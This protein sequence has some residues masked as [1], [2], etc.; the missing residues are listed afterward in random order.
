LKK[1]NKIF[2]IAID[3]SSASG[4]T[5]GAKFISKKFNFKFLS[6]GKLYR[7]LS[8]K[9]IQNKYNYDQKFILYNSK[10]IT[11]EKLNNNKNLYS[12][13]ITK[14]ASIIAKKKY[15]RLALKKFQLNFIKKNNKV[16]IEGRD[17]ASKIIPNANLK[18]FFKCSIKEK[19]KRRLN[20]F[21]KKNKH[22]TINEVEKSL[23]LRDFNDRNRKESPLLF[24]KGAVLVDTTK[25]TKTQM[26]AKL[27]KLVRKSLIKK[28]GN[29]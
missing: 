29:I 14:I 20:E 7:Y 19:A 16:I 3:G 17:I 18:I 9:I 24:V 5:T 11:L 26:K 1:K 13:E 23:K 4:K 8:Y 22:I 6:S 25:L 27:V 28:Y 10:N 21:K 12:P 15:I 2:S